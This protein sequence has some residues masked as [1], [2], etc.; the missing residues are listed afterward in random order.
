MN[1]KKFE[2]TLLIELD[3]R[4]AYLGP[5]FSFRPKVKACRRSIGS[6]AEFQHRPVARSLVTILGT[7]L[8]D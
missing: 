7:T 3:F 6:V 1:L 8:P 4:W 2:M 5:V